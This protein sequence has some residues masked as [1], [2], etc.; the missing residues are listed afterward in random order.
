MAAHWNVMARGHRART[1]LLASVACAVLSLTACGDSG[2]EYVS[3]SDAGL[4]FRVPDEWA[5]MEV[6]TTDEA[7][8]ETLGSTDEWL[9][10]L[11]RSPSPD[12]ANLTSA[13]PLH[14][15][16]V[17]SVASVGTLD[18]RDQLDYA[19]LRTMA[20]DGVGD[21]LDLAATDGSGV[22]LVSIEDI[23]T[24]DGLRGERVVFTQEQAD[25]SLLTIDQIAMVDPQTTEIYRL[26]L[27]CEA[28]CYESNRSEIDDIADSWT[29]DQED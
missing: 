7:V 14:P 8:P 28:H 5:V 12:P 25:G 23:T 20:T 18:D 16:G 26:L 9:R 27:K 15:V 6:D 13:L 11:D 4:H 1:V 22:E 10:V 17:A 3:N 2:Y 21:P 29:V 24:D 19:T